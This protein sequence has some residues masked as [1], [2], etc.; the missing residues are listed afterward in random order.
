[1]SEG[2]YIIKDDKRLCT[3]SEGF[4]PLTPIQQWFVNASF[5]R[6]YKEPT[7]LLAENEYL[8]MCDYDG[9]TWRMYKNVDDMFTY[10]SE[11]GFSDV[12]FKRFVSEVE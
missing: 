7:D 5:K 11:H 6:N 8:A 12:H 9:G 4:Y 2:C 3:E 1:M 10:M